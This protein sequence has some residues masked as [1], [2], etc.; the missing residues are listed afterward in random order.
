MV[1]SSGV[2]GARALWLLFGLTAMASPALAD[3]LLIDWMPTTIS[4]LLVS[5]AQGSADVQLDF[6]NP[7]PTQVAYL[8]FVSD[9][10]ACV[11]P[12]S[13]PAWASA[14]NS[15]NLPPQS[16][17][18]A[19]VNVAFD[20]AGLSDGIYATWLCVM[21]GENFARTAIPVRLRV[22]PPGYLFGDGFE[23]ETPD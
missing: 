8:V 22:V 1:P 11:A 20:A 18:S 7:T 16:T 17:F 9:D 19:T 10:S 23:S 21:A 2:V 12:P 4:A 5:T 3:G 15:G 13:A 14:F 6:Q